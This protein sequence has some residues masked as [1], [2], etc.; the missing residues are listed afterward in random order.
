MATIADFTDVFSKNY[1]VTGLPAD[2][3]EEIAGL[4]E[5]GCKLAGESLME[6]GETSSD[7]FVIL[8]GTVN[9]YTKQG[10]KL[11]DATPG[12]VLGE[13]ALVDAGPRSA[14]AVCV[15]LVKYAQLPAKTLRKY[16]AD[17]KEIGFTMLAN[18]SRVLSMRLRNS[19]QVMEH[20][21]AETMDP[22]ENSI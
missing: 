14:N 11:G 20:L 12:A 4:A 3:I 7:L 10:D 1:L 16:M 17:N 15:G 2:A 13:I 21:R 18:L 5:Y 6:K 8:E 22:W 9:V 19:A